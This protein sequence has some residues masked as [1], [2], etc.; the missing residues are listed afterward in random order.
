MRAGLHGEEL[1]Q[2]PPIADPHSIGNAADYAGA[3]GADKDRLVISAEGSRLLLHWDG[4]N[5]ALE[6]RGDDCFYVAHPDWERYLLEFGRDD[7]RVVEAFH[8]PDWYPGEA[9]AGPVSFDFPVEWNSYPGHY[10]AHNFVMTNFRIVLRKGGL[11]VVYPP[12]QHDRLV[13]IGDGSFRVGEAPRCPETISFDA[14]A[15]GRALRA[16]YSGCPYYRTYTP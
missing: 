16:T 11:I 12:G 7:G 6:Q 5:I 13:P 1:P 10:R 9:Y 15:S 14:L 8:G 2:P 3:Y 4:N